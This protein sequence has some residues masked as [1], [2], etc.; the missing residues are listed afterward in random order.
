MSP[1]MS[2]SLIVTDEVLETFSFV[3]RKKSRM[4]IVF[5]FNIELWSQPMHSRK[6]FQEEIKVIRV[7]KK[8]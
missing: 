3:I 4:F 1:K 2:T 5:F 6:C 7:G 8:K